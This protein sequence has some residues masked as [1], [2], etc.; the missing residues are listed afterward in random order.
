MNSFGRY[1]M[2]APAALDLPRRESWSM[3]NLFKPKLA[4]A[5]ETHFYTTERVTSRHATRISQML[6]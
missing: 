2:Q 3:S 6:W 4:H 5:Q 1:S